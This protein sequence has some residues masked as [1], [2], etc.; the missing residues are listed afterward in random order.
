MTD[1]KEKDKPVEPKLPETHGTYDTI[2]RVLEENQVDHGLLKNKLGSTIDSIDTAFKQTVMR[3]SRD[4]I[5]AAL[6]I[7]QS[8]DE[9]N[10]DMLT[11]ITCVDN[12]RRDDFEP[13]R[14]FTMIYVVYS[15]SKKKR[16]R[17]EVDLPEQ[18][19]SIDCA[20][21]VYKGAPW[22][23]REVYDMFGIIFNNH[24]KLERVLLPDYFEHHPLRKDYQLTGRGERDNFVHAEG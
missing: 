3:T 2:S 14:R 4:K 21:D 8:D 16:V 18:D 17:I 10:F 1:D 11:D 9:L 23:E 22:V 13:E 6:K 15:F 7:L 20:G 19:P 24:P 12:M 5:V